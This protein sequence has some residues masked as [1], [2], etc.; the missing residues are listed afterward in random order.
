MDLVRFWKTF[1]YLEHNPG[2]VDKETWWIS[3]ES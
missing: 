2:D 3:S 1:D